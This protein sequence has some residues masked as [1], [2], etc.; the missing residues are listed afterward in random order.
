MNVRK[1]RKE[2]E[3]VPNSIFPRQWQCLLSFLDVKPELLE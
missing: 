2:Q 1:Q 3:R